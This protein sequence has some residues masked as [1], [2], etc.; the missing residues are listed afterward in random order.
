[1]STDVVFSRKI[2]VKS[3][4]KVF[5]VRN[6]ASHFLRGLPLS[7]RSYRLQLALPMPKS[8]PAYAP[9]RNFSPAVPTT[10]AYKYLST[11][12]RDNRIAMIMT[13]SENINIAGAESFVHHMQLNRCIIFSFS[14]KI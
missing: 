14:C 10:R 12:S 8:H 4:K 9:V 2:S 7:P 6:K 3:K 11:I 1:M 5:V 13:T